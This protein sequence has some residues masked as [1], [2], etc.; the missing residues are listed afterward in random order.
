MHCMANINWEE[1]RIQAAISALQGIQES[2]K[3]GW[4]LEVMPEKAADLAVQMADALVRELQKPQ[5]QFKR[6][7]DEGDDDA[8]SMN[9]NY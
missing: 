7:Y 4:A 2:G 8:F 1:V 5:K 3:L 6:E 9:D